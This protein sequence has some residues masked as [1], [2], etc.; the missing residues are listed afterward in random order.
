MLDSPQGFPL[1]RANWSFAAL[2]DYSWQRFR[3]EMYRVA[4]DVLHGMHADPARVFSRGRKIGRFL[5]QI[6]A[7]LAVVVPFGVACVVLA[8]IVVLASGGVAA[9]E[10]VLRGTPTDDAV[11]P[12]FV[13]PAVLLALAAY[14]Y[15][16]IPLI[17]AQIELALRDHIGPV[18]AIRNAF[19]VARGRR[20]IAIV[21]G[22]ASGIVGVIGALACCVG[23][24]PAYGL[25]MLLFAGTYL[26]LRNGAALPVPD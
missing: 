16:L 4:L 2:L 8:G 6:L 18:E 3:S 15:L 23:V 12:Y 20:L 11:N 7:M 5:L 9:L 25:S 26:A 14:A 21:T 10:N 19:A 17:F 22:I 1:S 24:F 13:V